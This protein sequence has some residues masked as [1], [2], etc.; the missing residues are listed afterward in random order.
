[1]LSTGVSFE[2]G[3]KFQRYLDEIAK[4]RILPPRPYL[5]GWI[6]LNTRS[7]S[8][9]DATCRIWFKLAT[10][11]GDFVKMWNKEG[12]YTTLLS[13]VPRHNICSML[14]KPKY[15]FQRIR[16][17]I[18]WKNDFWIGRNFS[19]SFAEKWFSMIFELDANLWKNFS[20][21]FA[22]KWFSWH[23]S[24]RPQLLLISW[25][26]EASMNLSWLT[27]KHMFRF[28][29]EVPQDPTPCNCT[30][31]ICHSVAQFTLF[32]NDLTVSPPEKI[33]KSTNQWHIT[34]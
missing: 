34:V 28:M 16:L 33:W 1:M 18:F 17:I 14:R 4:F 29:P 5:R 10:P 11:Y 21:S 32:W 24:R 8:C 3:C 27:Y 26:L 22:E 31:N 13:R 9:V 15:Q 30:S 19:F 7:H 2:S 6:Q 25:K 20:F 23:D 12:V